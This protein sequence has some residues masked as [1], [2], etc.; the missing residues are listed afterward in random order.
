MRYPC[1]SAM[2]GVATIAVRH[3]V[4]RFSLVSTSRYK[5]EVSL[6]KI[7][8]KSYAPENDGVLRTL[9]V[10]GVQFDIIWT[11]VSVNNASIRIKTQKKDTNTA[12]L[13]IN[14]AL[15]VEQL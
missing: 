8:P 1:V 9:Q 14:L 12:K 13:E 3:G 11:I 4:W 2:E 7:V 10:S 15:L 6:L 5:I